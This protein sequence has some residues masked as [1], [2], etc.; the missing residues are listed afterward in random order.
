MM[1]AKEL[2]DL[3]DE[4]V[5]TYIERHFN[6]EL[7]RVLEPKEIY[8]ALTIIRVKIHLETLLMQFSNMIEMGKNVRS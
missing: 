2:C 8:W 7:D 1:T 4:D 6:G 3:G 5:S